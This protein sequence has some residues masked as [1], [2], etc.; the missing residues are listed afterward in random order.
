MRGLVCGDRRLDLTRPRVM[1]VLNVTPDS[2]SDGGELVDSNGC[3]RRDPI[4]HRASAMVDAGASLLDIGGESTR[5]GA[6]TASVAQEMD[7][8]L[9]V[10][11]WLLGLDVM[12]SVDTSKADVIREA[13]A[14]G[15]HL[16]NDVRALR[17]D[18]ALDALARTSAGVC[19]MH[20]RG[21]PVTMQA[22]PVYDDVA[23]EVRNFLAERLLAAQTAGIARSRCVVDPGIGFG[24]TFE[25][26]LALLAKLP[27]LDVLGVPV[28]VGISRK[29]MIGKL[30]GRGVKE[31]VAGSVAAA[32]Y[33]VM[34]GARIVRVHDVAQTVD[35]LAVWHALAGQ[36]TSQ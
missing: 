31:R 4:M 10:V 1:G 15:A 5:P 7:R 9:P 25:H 35:A 23:S 18:G 28:M 24:K 16:I 11:E 20:M 8:V 32:L 33:A 27:A 17:S 12:I 3:P 30:T 19:L 21:E 29:S 13:C 22:E 6:L 14:V 34:R 26:N 2:F 36:D